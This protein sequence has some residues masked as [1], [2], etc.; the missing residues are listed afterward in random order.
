MIL[1]KV[2]SC[3][4]VRDLVFL[5]FN[6]SVRSSQIKW[7]F[8][9]LWLWF[10]IVYIPWSKLALIGMI[11]ALLIGA[12]VCTVFCLASCVVAVLF[13]IRRIR[14]FAG[15]F[16]FQADEQGVRECSR[17]I[18]VTLPWASI[19]SV[20]WLSKYI[21]IQTKIPNFIIALKRQGFE[22]DQA[23]EDFYRDIKDRIGQKMN[24]M[25]KQRIQLR[26]RDAQEKIA[27]HAA[28]VELTRKLGRAPTLKE[29]ERYRWL[30]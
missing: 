28:T 14:Y 10:A 1:W 12:L 25:D 2:I 7:T 26:T 11:A 13:N 22:S 29:V 3:F 18:G 9:L 4:T 19:T 21:V 5:Q 27:L 15:S 16:E 6:Y 23:C 20:K 30:G 24:V 17:I 8:L